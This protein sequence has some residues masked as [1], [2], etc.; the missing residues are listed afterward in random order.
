MLVNGHGG[1]TIPAVYA[2]A[3][4]DSRGDSAA[5]NSDERPVDERPVRIRVRG[6]RR[7][8]Q[9]EFTRAERNGLLRPG[10]ARAPL[11]PSHGGAP[12]PDYASGDDGSGGRLRYDER[13]NC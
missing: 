1:R 13:L 9:S 8:F 6:A 4:G 7:T 5:T 12:P 10:R 3:E 2:Y 11:T